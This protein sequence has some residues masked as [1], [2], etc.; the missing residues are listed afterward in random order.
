M[1]SRYISGLDAVNRAFDEL[2]QDAREG[3]KE[4][5]ANTVAFAQV[6]IA[7]QIDAMDAVDKGRLKGSISGK[8]EGQYAFNPADSATK[9][10]D[11]GLSAVVG[12]N[13]EYAIP[14]HDGYV[15]H[16]KGRT[17]RA[18]Y[19]VSRGSLSQARLRRAGRNSRYQGSL[20]ISGA[21]YSRSEQ[22]EIAMIVQGRPFMTAAIPAIEAEMQ[23]AAAEIIEQRLR[24]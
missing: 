10:A 19:G 17:V 9:I 14:V 11:D 5:V 18:A 15:R 20:N 12:T 22:G 13:V 8:S 3:M 4:V 16:L 21:S 24:R 2:L 7:D 1:S 23:R 6:E